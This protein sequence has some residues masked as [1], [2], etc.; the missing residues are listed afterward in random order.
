MYQFIIFSSA[1]PAGERYENEKW[2]VVCFRNSRR[3]VF[4]WPNLALPVTKLYVRINIPVSAS[5]FPAGGSG[6]RGAILKCCEE[7]MP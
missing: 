5:T 1:S 6:A 3:R 4:R 7:R 2:E